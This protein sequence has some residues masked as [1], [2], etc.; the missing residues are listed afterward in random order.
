MEP[1][2]TEADS[3]FP[4]GKWVGF[5]TDKRLAGKLPTELILTFRDGKMTGEGRDLV[6][7][8]TVLGRYAT[9]DGVCSWNKT[10]FR[11]HTVSYAGFNEGK[12]I[13]GTWTLLDHG[14]TFTGGFHIWPEGYGIDTGDRLREEADLP[15]AV[16]VR[17]LAPVG[18]LE[19]G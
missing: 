4:S 6:G 11:A 18:E 13:W 5:F 14:L 17:E 15:D 9:G 8:F 2:E 7:D 16:E 10:Y 19:G 1:M 12:G 3:R